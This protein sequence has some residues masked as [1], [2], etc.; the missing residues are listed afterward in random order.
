LNCFALDVEIGACTNLE[1][2]KKSSIVGCLRSY[3]DNGKSPN[4]RFWNAQ[5]G[6]LTKHI[7]DPKDKLRLQEHYKQYRNSVDL[8]S[9]IVLGSIGIQLI[10]LPQ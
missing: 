8:S 2:K 1:T 10:S 9:S 6:S 7:L 5:C 3:S 4:R